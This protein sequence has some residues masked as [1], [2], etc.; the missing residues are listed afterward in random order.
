MHSLACTNVGVKPTILEDVDRM[1]YAINKKKQLMC[2]AA[3]WSR[4][5]ML[6][7]I[8]IAPFFCT[9]FA[10]CNLMDHTPVGTSRYVVDFS[11]SFFDQTWLREIAF[12]SGTF[13]VN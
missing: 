1:G 12:L 11:G 8:F 5:H 2:P 6:Q 13:L 10:A 7:E 3:K 9:P 4:T